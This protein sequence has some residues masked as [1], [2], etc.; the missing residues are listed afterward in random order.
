[1]VEN[2]RDRMKSITYVDTFDI[3]ISRSDQMHDTTM[4]TPYTAEEDRASRLV[5]AISFSHFVHQVFIPAYILS[6]ANPGTIST[7]HEDGKAA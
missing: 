2:Y 7:A 4:P 5:E 6:P 1:M 3:L